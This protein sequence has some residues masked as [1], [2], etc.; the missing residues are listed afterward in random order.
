[1]GS[2]SVVPMS[3]ITLHVTCTPYWNSCVLTPISLASQCWLMEDWYALFYFCS[4]LSP[5]ELSYTFWRIW[6]RKEGGKPSRP[7]V[8]TSLWLS[9]SFFLCI[10]MYVRP[11][12][13]FPTDKSLSAF[14]TV[15]SPMLNPLIY[16]LRN[17][18]LTNAMKK[19]WRKLCLNK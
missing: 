8:P 7:V 13:T 3:L 18:E 12:K 2:H 5:M 19:L 10:F 16:S 17:S 9:A 4:Y 1:M 14:Y 15:I 6:V 11:A